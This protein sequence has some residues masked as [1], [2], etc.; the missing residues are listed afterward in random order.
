[1]NIY[2]IC[3]GNT[4]R[5]PMAEAILR[6]KNLS[7]IAVRS[8]GLHAANGFPISMHS[9]TLIQEMDMPY[10]AVS[11]AIS[12]E[13][14]EWADL[15][16]TMTVG[17]KQGVL[18]RF[19]EAKGKLYTLKEYT[20]PNGDLDIQDPFGGNLLTYRETFEELTMYMDLLV[21]KLTEE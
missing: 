9:E 20:K 13:D 14:V 1:M 4:C 12:K 21:K 17:H 19:P 8:A 7:E 3:T 6:S 18:Q 15:I 5:S 16:L 10:T 11:R 2:L